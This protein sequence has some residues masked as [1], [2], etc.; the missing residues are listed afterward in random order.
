MWFT[1]YAPN[2]FNKTEAHMKEIEKT[3]KQGGFYRVDLTN[4]L[5]ILTL[6]TN[7]MSPRNVQDTEGEAIM[8]HWLEE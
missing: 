3:F 5:T 8:L 6:N 4:E 1:N 7:Y 2:H